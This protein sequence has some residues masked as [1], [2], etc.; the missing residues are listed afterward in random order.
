MYEKVPGDRR[1]AVDD[2]GAQSLGALAA[3]WYEQY[4]A[5][6]ENEGKSTSHSLEMIVPTFEQLAVFVPEMLQQRPA[7]EPS[8][9]TVWTDPITGQAARN[10][11]SEPKD[12][13]SQSVIAAKDPQLAEHLKAVALRPRR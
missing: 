12:L 10:P 1:Y 13:T 11:W 9:P 4:V 2:N 5:R 3:A 8:S 6:Q 7:P